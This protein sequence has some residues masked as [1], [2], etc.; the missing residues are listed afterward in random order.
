MLVRGHGP[1]FVGIFHTRPPPDCCGHACMPRYEAPFACRR[2]RLT[3]TPHELTSYTKA[4]SSVAP[5][6]TAQIDSYT[7][8]DGLGEMCLATPPLTLVAHLLG[9]FP[10]LTNSLD[11]T[12][13]ASGGSIV[14]LVLWSLLHF[15]QLCPPLCS[16][17]SANRPGV[18]RHHLSLCPLRA[19]PYIYIQSKAL[20]HEHGV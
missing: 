18:N 2:R 6:L 9:S 8:A 10:L 4:L 14:V 15:G 17:V 13:K 19:S 12:F 20:V 11:L 3:P 1:V 5:W 7:R 16:A